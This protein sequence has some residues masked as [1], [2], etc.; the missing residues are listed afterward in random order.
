[1]NRNIYLHEFRIRLKSV[2]VWSLATTGLILFFFSLFTV[3]IDQAELMK[4][5][6][7]RYPPQLLEAF[8]M[9]KMDVSSVLGFYSLVFLFVQLCL[10]IQA[11]NYGFGLV[12]I[13]ESE[14]TADFLLSKPVSR[15]QILTSKLLAAISSLTVTNLV[16]W[17]ASL[18]AI[19]LFREGHDYDFGLL[20][21]ML[22]SIVILQVSF[23][24]LGL[25]ISLLVKRVRSVTP[26]ALGLGF[27]AYVLNAFGGMLGDVPIELLTPFKH[28]DAALM[29]Q[30]G[31][32][33]LPLVI[34]NI[35]IS[36]IAVAASYW[37]Y[38]RRDIHAVS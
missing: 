18:I 27:G 38:N 37:L 13:E 5:L 20:I 11:S 28:L 12:S 14:L 17:A 4:E 33:D 35:S 22:L 21:L 29:V 1:M 34:L 9:T 31:G 23:L 7:K 24:S 16:V 19:T 32:Y 2:L 15:Y 26:F 8:G 10:A 30:S 25:V 3:F 6:L 36:I